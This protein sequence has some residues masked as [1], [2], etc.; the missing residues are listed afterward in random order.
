MMKRFRKPLFSFVLIAGAIFAFPGCSSSTWEDAQK[1]NTYEAY[2]QYMADNPEGEHLN[3]ARNRADSLY[4]MDIKDD[5]TKALFRKYLEEFPRGRFHAEA[6]AR[7]NP[8]PANARVT[9]AGVIIR[10][11]HTTESPSVGVVAKAGTEVEVLDQ[12]SAGNSN[13]AI[14][15]RQVNVTVNGRDITL[16][17]GKALRI[18]ADQGDS[19]QASF[20]S[21]EFGPTEAMISKSDIEAMEGETWYKITTSDGIT[22]WIYGQFIQPL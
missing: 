7:L 13:E 14:L 9:G 11:D 2:R 10:A 4:W 21:T 6:E 3:V 17:K 8:I 18:V 19:V 12:Y 22:G 15:N 5:T 20:S 16:G 1:A